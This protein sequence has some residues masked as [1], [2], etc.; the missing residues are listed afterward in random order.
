MHFLGYLMRGFKWRVLLI[1]L[2]GMAGIT[3]SLLFIY[4]SKLVIDTATGVV[5]GQWLYYAVLMA[6]TLGAQAILRLVGLSLTNR[7]AVRMG[8]AIRTR[9]FGHLLYT[10]WQHLGQL[11]SGDM[12]TRIIKDTDE[13][14]QLLIS[15]IPSAILAGLQ[16]VAS[17]V[18]MYIYSPILAILLGVGMPLVLAFGRIFY[19]RMLG[20]SSEIKGIESQINQHMHEA[21]GNQTVI[22]TFERQGSVLN[23][24]ELIQNQLY[25]SVKKRV[26]LTIYGNLMTS[27]A[28]SGGYII[29]FLWSAWALR[30]GLIQFGTMTAFLQLV[31]RIQRPMVE[32]L[33]IVPS[34]IASKASID[35]L[36]SVLEYQTESLGRGTLLSGDVGLELRDV[37]FGYADADTL[38]LEQFSLSVTPGMMVSIMGPTGAGKTTLLRLMLGLVV[39][40]SGSIRLYN[41]EQSIEVSEATRGHFVYVPQGNTLLS[42]TIRENLLVGD[43]HADDKRMYE[44]L[45]IATAD[46]VWELPEGLNTPI[47][48]RGM[49]LS[50][51]QAQRIAIARSL[52]RPGRILLFD[53][54]TS[55][56]DLETEQRL[57]SNLRQHID[58]RIIIFITHHEEVAR[59]SDQVIRI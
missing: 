40:T 21:L 49:G 44:V 11:R 59:A 33:S 43:A 19:R 20:F 56:L 23:D 50:E 37:T 12:L 52:L 4:L 27:A 22:R 51:G 14:V 53:E 3:C 9:I 8:N 13:V 6:L 24:L 46:F 48:E 35:R 34:M 32:L 47:G 36:V 10:R 1:I 41:H 18:M 39:P 15:T 29:A 16:L 54:A 38:V 30:N 45:R 7:T 57:L 58:G 5:A 55:A 28:F 2:V 31:N 42:G 25:S 17:L 26:G